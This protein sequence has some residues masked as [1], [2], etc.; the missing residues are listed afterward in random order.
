MAIEAPTV[1]T[2]LAGGVNGTL[3]CR[4]PAV[5]GEQGR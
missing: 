4:N 2:D 1:A 5:Q 3:D